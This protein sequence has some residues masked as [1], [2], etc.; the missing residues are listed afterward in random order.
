MIK[1]GETLSPADPPNV[2]VSARTAEGHGPIRNPSTGCGAT[3][4]RK[5]TRAWITGREAHQNAGT[6][7]NAT[8][9]YSNTHDD[10]IAYTHVPS[11][12]IRRTCTIP[13]Q[14]ET[15]VGGP[16]PGGPRSLT[17]GPGVPCLGSRDPL[18]LEKRYCHWIL[19]SLD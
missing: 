13:T 18:P 1:K 12:T 8:L 9:I 11:E 3:Q 2:V 19:A 15:V 6:D 17:R 14:K 4:R 7:A 5:N 16:V 10:P